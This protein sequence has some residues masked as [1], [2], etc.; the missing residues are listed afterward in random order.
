MT[1]LKY[2][3]E[4]KTLEAIR[5]QR[6]TWTWL[7]NDYIASYVKAANK[8][9]YHYN[10][11]LHTSIDM[12]IAKDIYMW[13]DD[14]VQAYASACKDGFRV[15]KF[16]LSVIYANMTLL[17]LVNERNKV[18]RERDHYEEQL[19]LLDKTWKET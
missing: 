6:D 7:L 14:P 19:D 5:Q 4:R 3:K 2:R 13:D 9:G 17:D 11:I 12:N 16:F 8:K 15:I 18:A 10:D 1:Y